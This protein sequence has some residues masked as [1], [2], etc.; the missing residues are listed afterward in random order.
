M[1]NAIR[2]QLALTLLAAT[3]LLA[4]GVVELET[5][6]TVSRIDLEELEK[7]PIAR[8]FSDLASLVPNVVG[9]TR[10]SGDAGDYSVRVRGA[11]QP[12]PLRIEEGGVTGLRIG[13]DGSTTPIADPFQTSFRPR[14]GS[15]Q[16]GCSIDYRVENQLVTVQFATPHGTVFVSAPEIAPAGSL[17]TWTATAIP[18]G[19]TERERA[20]NQRRLDDLR[21]QIGEPPITLLPGSSVQVPAGRGKRVAL[22]D[23]RTTLAAGTIPFLHSPSWNGSTGGVDAGGSTSL[24]TVFAGGALTIPGH[25]DGRIGNTRVLVGGRPVRIVAESTYGVSIYTPTDQIGAC[26]IVVQE[27]TQRGSGTFYN[28]GLA[29][30]ADKYDLLRGETT[31]CHVDLRGLAGL[32]RPVDLILINRTPGVVSMAPGNRQLV[33]I[34]PGAHDALGTLRIDRTF[35]GIQRGQFNL[36]AILLPPNARLPGA[37]R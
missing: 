11:D 34:L 15:A 6:A 21:I 1:P 3:P 14:D 33:R 16:S 13:P 5:P 36:R 8:D 29:I 30:S 24:P 12:V 35:T 18:A 26:D 31:T 17:T 4:D 9:I 27:G 23:G 22:V 20:R 37:P 7:V 32:N 10:F 19:A 25:F 2:R 28:L